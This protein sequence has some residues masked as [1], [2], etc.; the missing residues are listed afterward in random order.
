MRQPP[1]KERRPGGNQGGAQMHEDEDGI[2][3]MVTRCPLA[4]AALASC[5]SRIMLAVL[6]YHPAGRC[7]YREA[8]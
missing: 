7:A 5:D 2:T 8:A 6:T 3:A 1:D 4:R